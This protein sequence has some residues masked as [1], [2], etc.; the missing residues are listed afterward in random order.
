M[1]N[2]Y[3]YVKPIKDNLD[4]PIKERLKKEILQKESEYR[5]ALA[6]D[7]EFSILKEIRDQLKELNNQYLKESR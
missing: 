4:K 2:L 5:E 3:Q 1:T 6:S 7:A